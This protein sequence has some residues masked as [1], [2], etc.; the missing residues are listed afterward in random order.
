MSHHGG[1]LEE[2]I[3]LISIIFIHCL[4]YYYTF[5]L[6]YSLILLY[7]EVTIIYDLFHTLLCSIWLYIGPDII[8]SVSL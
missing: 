3:P 4:V 6:L 1:V 8:S 5:T 7:S 2:V